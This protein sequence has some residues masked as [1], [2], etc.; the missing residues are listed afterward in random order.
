MELPM[1][2]SSLGFTIDLSGSLDTAVDAVTGALAAEGFGILTRIDVHTTLK[3]K[4]DQEFRPYIILGACNPQ[5]AHRALTRS[6]EVGLMLPCNVT[7]ETV[8][9]GK[10]VVRIADPAL[11]MGAGDLGE[12]A[13]LGEVASE[14][15]EKLQRVA[16]SL[17]GS[18]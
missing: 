14:A 6:A 15:R 1:T 2:S 7:V 13:V 12:D 5:L 17:G 3:Q 8:E 16:V 10:V 4:L 9:P 11:L 18:V